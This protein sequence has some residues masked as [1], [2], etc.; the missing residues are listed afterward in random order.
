MK[1]NQV[2]NYRSVF[3]KSNGINKKNAMPVAISP[4]TYAVIEN[5]IQV[6]GDGSC[7]VDDYVKNVLQSKLCEI[8]DVQ[9]IASKA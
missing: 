8:N 5:I 9:C 1:K 4:T 2:S 7:T 6:M 3:L